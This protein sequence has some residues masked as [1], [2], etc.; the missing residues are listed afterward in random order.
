MKRMILITL[1]LALLIACGSGPSTTPGIS[2]AGAPDV[3]V[4][5]NSIAFTC[6][7]VS[8]DQDC[9]SVLDGPGIFNSGLVAIS[10]SP[11]PPDYLNFKIT[12][13]LANITPVFVYTDISI[14]GCVSRVI[15]YEA[16]NAAPGA[17]LTASTA[18]WGYRCGVPDHNEAVLTIYN[19]SHF[20][21]LNYASPAVYPRD[22]AIINAVV[23]WKNVP[24]IW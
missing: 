7:G 12:S 20:N 6:I 5:V 9:A 22:Q 8:N 23:R 15:A 2:N 11:P 1:T 18:L 24:I 4:A 3:A 13:R 21:P 16:V 14:V 19:A 17:I 10:G